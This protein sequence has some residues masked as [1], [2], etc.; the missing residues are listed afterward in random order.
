MDSRQQFGGAE[1]FGDVIGG[2]HLEGEGDVGIA[3]SGRE[4]DDGDVPEMGRLLELTEDFEAVDGGKQDIQEDE[5][6]LFLAHEGEDDVAVVGDEGSETFLAE[7]EL[8]ELRDE[9][10]VFDDKDFGHVR[11]AECYWGSLLAQDD[12]ALSVEMGSG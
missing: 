5:V 12:F 6:G 2:A 3:V 7:E 11:A 1:G 8:D 9:L 4:Q 10:L